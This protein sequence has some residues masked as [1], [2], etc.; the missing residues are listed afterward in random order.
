MILF[1]Q[2]N[3][4]NQKDDEKE[5]AGQKEMPKHGKPGSAMNKKIS[6]SPINP[7]KMFKQAKNPQSIFNNIF[8]YIFLML[9]AY[10]IF[11]S[12]FQNN[13]GTDKKPISDLVQLI[14]ED[15][16]Q[17]ITVAGD[18][19]EVQLKD[20][21][22]FTTEKETSISFDDILSNNNVDRSKIAGEIKVEHRV[23]LEDI[24]SPILMIGLPLLLIYF[25]FRQMRGASSDIFSFGKSRAK[26]FNKGM[27]KINFQDVAGNE[28]A[29]TEMMEI[30]DF[31]KN[32]EKY[33]KLGARTPKGILLVGPS[34]VGKTLLAKAIAGEAEVPFFSV[35][36]SE[37]M[38][39]LVGVG[40]ARVR[41]LFLMA[42]ES[43]PSMIF[44]DE[45]D[46][47][48]RQR[49]MGIGGGHDEREQTLN[50]ILIEMDGF[51]VRTDVIVV[52]ASVTGE[53]PVMIRKNG[54]VS[55]KPISEVIDSYFE[56]FEEGE[57]K[58]SSD[59]EALSYKQNGTSIVSKFTSVRGVFR[60]KVNE[61]Y[62]INYIGGKVRTTGNHSVFI[63]SGNAVVARPVST[64][65]KGDVLVDITPKKFDD[66]E[67][68]NDVTLFERYIRTYPENKE[69][70]QR[71]EYVMANKGI[72][73]QEKL[74]E[75][76]G[77]AQTTISLWHRGIN[78]PRGLSRNYYFDVI[79]EDIKIT[80]DLMRLFGYYTAEGY[81]RKEID[82][83]FNEKEEEY[84]E[85]VR[86]LML[87]NFG[88]LPQMER[89]STKNAVNL[90]YQSK[91]IANVFKTY[92]GSGSKNKHVPEFLF[93]APFIYYKEYLKGVARGDGHIDKKGRLA[94]TS[95]SRR[96]VTELLWLSRIHG[97][98]AS[99]S[100][101]ATLEGRRIS[102]GKP[103]HS[104]IAYRIQFGKYY[105]LL[106]DEDR[107]YIKYSIKKPVIKSIEKLPYDGYVYDFCGCENEAFFIGNSPVLGHNTNRPDMLDP[108][109]IRAGRFDRKIT[110]PLPDLKDREEIIKIHMRGKPFLKDV[111]I[112]KIA[113]KT[114]GFSGADIENM[115]NEA[116]ILA[117]RVGRVEI[118]A[119]DVDEASLKV[120]MGSERKTL[121][122]EQERKIT[123]YHESGHAL[124]ATYVPEMDP[125]NRV[126]I[127][128]RGGSL[129]HT[130][131][132]PER[133]R[134][135]E[136]KTR[137]LS[138]ISTM[139]GGRAAE[140][141]VFN[142]LTV[143]A[144][145]DIERATKLTRKMVT[146]FGMSSL[147]PISYNGKD[148]NFWLAR[149]L[150]ET[151]SY[152]QEMA[153]KI[154]AEVKRIIDEC[155]SR[156]KSILNEHREKL[157]SV[158]EVLLQKET[159]DGD[160][161]LQLVKGGGKDGERKEVD[162][163]E[164]R[165]KAEENDKKPEVE[166]EEKKENE[167]EVFSLSS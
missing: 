67:N 75:E 83:C 30:V 74:A 130:S 51:D 70:T 12:F 35:A 31:L 92:C 144:A 115:L 121:Q 8:F 34:G 140:E 117:A 122:S 45:I 166:K 37:F 159:L 125:V 119:E 85:D 13:I 107:K 56:S 36:G 120:T 11:S 150:G 6:R 167:K 138:L 80:P 123:S 58:P 47:I 82:F 4:N 28:E 103:L 163:H 110:I 145:D 114:V 101:F 136:T 73:S 147:G 153:A 88:L 131:F 127:V 118:S 18:S 109:L 97:V 146:E 43:Q 152:S 90:I 65:K 44:I 39:M 14:N 52:A 69:L 32:P 76:T 71:Y 2:N 158:S 9:F 53:T 60:H 15:K 95:V 154:D 126:S 38:E 84:L 77:F 106:S 86:K 27:S 105:N 20:G 108:A 57:E 19:I 59:L 24:L 64:L 102:G 33:R 25:I 49:G 79:D 78:I 46:A 137:L 1:N 98:K 142:E 139:L 54:M 148:N 111:D 29:K 133:D 62:E 113:K 132:P 128:A 22:E 50:Q 16:V 129:G 55:L 5:K 61:I 155:Y 157:N 48:G 81:A 112:T 42:K 156:A 63:W 165:M 7:Q 135:N 116:A 26:L 141:I 10:I 162:K 99:V 91:P 87:D 89:R 124:V 164:E 143:G 100:S 72:I 94:V 96:L 68:D 104:S 149:E 134:Y 40:S 17:N 160:E 21:S 23:G 161:F 3:Q 41:D 66:L 93:E 151:P